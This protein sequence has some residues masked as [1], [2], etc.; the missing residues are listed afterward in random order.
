MTTGIMA[1]ISLIAFHDPC[2]RGR[3]GIFEIFYPPP[4]WTKEP[5]IHRTTPKAAQSSHIRTDFVS[6]KNGEKTEK[7]QN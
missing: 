3:V 7:T 1:L 4:Q 2:R 5:V 6:R